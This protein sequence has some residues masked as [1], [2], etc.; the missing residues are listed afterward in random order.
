MYGITPQLVFQSKQLLSALLPSAINLSGLVFQ[1]SLDATP[2][3]NTHTHSP[4]T[5]PP[6][7]TWLGHYV[8]TLDHMCALNTQLC[9]DLKS[10]TGLFPVFQWFA[11]LMGLRSQHAG[12][13]R[14]WFQNPSFLFYCS[15]PPKKAF[16]SWSL[17]SNLPYSCSSLV[18][19][20][21][22]DFTGMPIIFF[23]KAT[24]VSFLIKKNMLTGATKTS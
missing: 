18:W 23:W 12:I 24:V 15:K 1:C 13:P 6:C 19:F 11:R 14:H 8:M 10:R 5:P 4:P 9:T 16:R 2:V 21:F 7:P 3:A 22:S 20:F 17:I